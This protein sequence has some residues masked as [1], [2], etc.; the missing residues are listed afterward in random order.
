MPYSIDSLEAETDPFADA[1]QGEAPEQPKT[2]GSECENMKILKMFIKTLNECIFFSSV[3][4]LISKR[5][6]T[7]RKKEAQSKECNC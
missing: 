5:K 6:K 7:R 4:F 2:N 3:S 1:E